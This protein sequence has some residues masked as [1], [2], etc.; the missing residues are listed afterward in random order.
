MSEGNDTHGDTGRP[1]I[2]FD[3]DGTIA[4][5]GRWRG[6]GHI[7]SP[8]P[9]M[10]ALL[11]RLH[12]AGETVKIVTAR[13][14]PRRDGQDVVRARRIVERWCERNLGF[15][16]AITYKKDASMIALYDDRVIQVE[17]N[18]GRILG[19]D[20]VSERLE[21][22]LGRTALGEEVNVADGSTRREGATHG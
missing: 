19:R 10:V 7:G 9:S 3:L 15:V 1:W 4:V 18:T 12:E 13:V 21:K 11:K 8:V 6:I 17:K 16:P 5:Y 22:R 14:A 2:G 20:F